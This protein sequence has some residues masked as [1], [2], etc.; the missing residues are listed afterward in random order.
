VRINDRGPFSGARIIDVS[1]RSAQLLGFEAQ[2][3]AKVRVQVLADE[4]KAIA[5]A[6]RHYG[7]PTPAVLASSSAGA[8]PAELA[9]GPQTMGT[10]PQAAPGQIQTA[11]LEPVETQTLSPVKTTPEV[12]QQLLHTEPVPVVVQLPVTGLHQIYVQAGAFTVLE[13]AT[14]LQHNL[15]KI[16]TVMLSDV[17]I[18]GKLFHRVRVGPIKDVASAE[19]SADYCRLKVTHE[20]NPL[21]HS[22]CFVF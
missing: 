3:T 12:H 16:G 19:R 21:I 13:N 22:F 17:S 14:K 8:P 11:A 9:M 1:Q 6:M 5:D 4:S 2:G 10:A 7:A 20:K 18:N 15:S